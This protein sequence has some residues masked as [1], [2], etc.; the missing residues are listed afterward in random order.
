MLNIEASS[1]KYSF[2]KSSR[3]LKWRKSSFSFQARRILK[4]IQIPTN[5]FFVNVIY[6]FRHRYS[7]A[8]RAI[9]KTE[10]SVVCAEF[11]KGSKFHFS[12]YLIQYV[13][14]EM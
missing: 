11:R 6:S 10:N 12:Q 4:T 2:N 14:F 9:P 7:P 3:K 1:K 13:N 8:S 5:L